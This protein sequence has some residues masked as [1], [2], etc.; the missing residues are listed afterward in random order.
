VARRRLG[1]LS[2]SVRAA[3]RED[4]HGAHGVGD[5]TRRSRA[6]RHDA[7]GRLDVAVNH[8]GNAGEMGGMVIPFL[9]F[10]LETWTDIVTQNLT[11]TMMC[12]QAEALAM[13]RAVRGAPNC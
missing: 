8:V 9:D 5:T 10:T 3:A 2:V 7:F 1:G 11:G 13:I 4:E 12:C 6:E